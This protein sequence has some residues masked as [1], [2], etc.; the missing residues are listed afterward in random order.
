MNLVARFSEVES[1]CCGGQR[2]KQTE[3]RKRVDE[4]KRDG[5]MAKGG[6]RPV[7]RRSAR[8]RNKKAAWDAEWHESLGLGK[9]MRRRGRL[10]DQGKIAH[11]HKKSGGRPGSRSQ[12]AEGVAGHPGSRAPRLVN[13]C[14]ITARGVA[15]CLEWA[16]LPPLPACLGTELNGRLGL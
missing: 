8:S 16:R 10:A 14:P 3:A 7:R 6:T 15:G 11:A 4:A 13:A 9:G 5:E 2:P 12:N 1:K